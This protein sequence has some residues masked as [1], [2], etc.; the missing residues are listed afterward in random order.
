MAAIAH[1]QPRAA[2]QDAPIH[3][4]VADLAGHAGGDVGIIDRLAGV[5][6]Q[7]LHL[8]A[9][10]L[11]QIDD[12]RTDRIATMIGADG[13]THGCK[14]SRFGEVRGDIRSYA[15]FISSDRRMVPAGL[16]PTPRGF[17]RGC[18]RW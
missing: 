8:V 4:A 1:P 6:A 18:R 17:W 14:P 9:Q 7:V 16:V 15:R 10:P 12:P 13:N 3:L 11:Q 5:R 2:D